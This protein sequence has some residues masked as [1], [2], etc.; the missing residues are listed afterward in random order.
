MLLSLGVDIV[1]RNALDLA[2]LPPDENPY[3]QQLDTDQARLESLSEAML[4]RDRAN[5]PSPEERHSPA[6]TDEEIS[7][8]VDSVAEFLVAID[9]ADS[10]ANLPLYVQSVARRLA[11]REENLPRLPA[12]AEA[13]PLAL[14]LNRASSDAAAHHALAFAGVSQQTNPYDDL[15]TAALAELRVWLEQTQLARAGAESTPTGVKSRLPACTQTELASAYASLQP[16]YERIGGYGFA[17]EPPIMLAYSRDHIDS[18]AAFFRQLPGCAEAFHAGWRLAE[19][20]SAEAADVAFAGA[21]TTMAEQAGASRARAIA[22]LSR[23]ESLLDDQQTSASAQRRGAPAC[24][25]DQMV[26]F[27][28]YI[29]TAFHRF[30]EAALEA[31]SPADLTTLIEQAGS[32]RELLWEQLPRCGEALEAGWLMRRIASDFI[33]LLALESAGVDPLDIPYLRSIIDDMAALAAQIDALN[34][35]TFFAGGLIYYVNA[36]GYANIRACGSIECEAVGLVQRGDVLRVLDDASAWYKIQLS[37]GSAA[38]IAGFLASKTP[39][40]P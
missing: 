11:W 38:W 17:N 36:D 6:C 14:L 27:N 21:N 7:Q 15:E 9:D 20:I 40:S 4:N 29:A 12:C 16:A 31:K 22:A 1:A 18:R 23:L 24:R 28:V 39:P 19:A 25:D 37:D 5:A 33:A 35:D 34:D 2:S 30:T 13:I 3:R 8:I 26:F 10:I 32:L